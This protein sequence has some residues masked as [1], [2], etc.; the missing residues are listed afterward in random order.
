MAEKVVIDIG[1]GSKKTPG[2]IGVDC[3]RLPGVDVVADLEKEKLPFK[4]NSV[5]EAH[6]YGFLEHVVNFVPL[7]EEIWRVLKPGG[8]MHIMVPHF[9]DAGAFRDITHRRFFAYDSFTVFNPNQKEG[10]VYWYSK[11]R[12]KTVKRKLIFSKNGILF[13]NRLLEPLFNKIPHVWEN[14]P[15]RSFPA[16]EFHITI[17]K[18]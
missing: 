5:D 13:Y 3:A 9:T 1:C 17:E 16:Q 10:A 15:L 18:I 11:A 12:F 8:Q 14:T 4:D 6:A 2:A 7:M